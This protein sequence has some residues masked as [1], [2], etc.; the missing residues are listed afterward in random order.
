M[1]P[2]DTVIYSMKHYLWLKNADRW[3]NRYLPRTARRGRVVARDEERGLVMVLWNDEPSEVTT[4]FAD[5]LELV[6]T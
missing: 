1:K 3:S 2:D 4:H 5:N 6:E